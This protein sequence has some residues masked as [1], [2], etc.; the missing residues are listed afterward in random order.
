MVSVLITTFNSAQFLERCLNSV[1]RQSN[2]P[3]ELIIVD[4][5][6]TEGTQELRAKGGTGIK[7]LALSTTGFA[8]AQN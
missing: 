6:S 1:Q 5:A 3:V 8:A 2:Q 7:V 4:N